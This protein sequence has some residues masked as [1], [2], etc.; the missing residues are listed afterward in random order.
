VKAHVA[1]VG[2]MGAGKSSVGKA[3]ARRL[4]RPF[5]DS[6]ALVVAERGATIAKIFEEEGEAAFRD[7]E[8]AALRRAVD[9][10]ACVIAT[11]GGAVTHPPT[12]ALL[13]RHALRIYLSLTAGELSARLRRSRTRRPVLAGGP[14]R[15]RVT[16]LLATRDPLYREAE[17]VV[18]CDGMTRSQ[19]VHAIVGI[20]AERAP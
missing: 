2:M 15:D 19:V 3:L 18:P 10:E 12:R 20:L 13:A 9:G 6:D 16:A 7:Y 4:G 8:L 17:I 5:V 1:L 14:I 11:G